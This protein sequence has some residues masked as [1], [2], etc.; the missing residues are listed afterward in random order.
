MP[1]SIHVN[2]FVRGCLSLV[3]DA[4]SPPEEPSFTGPR[5][6]G[7]KNQGIATNPTRLLR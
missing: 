1:G 4:T 6:H 5:I 3:Q 2:T 7:G